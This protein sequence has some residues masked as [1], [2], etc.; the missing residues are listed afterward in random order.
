ME[1]LVNRSRPAI[2]QIWQRLGDRAVNG[3][4]ARLALQRGTGSSG[5]QGPGSIL[6]LLTANPGS[7]AEG[8]RGAE[9]QPGRARF[10]PSV[11]GNEH[12]NSPG[13][14]NRTGL[15][16]SVLVLSPQ[17]IQQTNG[18]PGLPALSEGTIPLPGLHCTRDA[19]SA[20]A[21]STYFSLCP[22]ADVRRSSCHGVYSAQTQVAPRNPASL[23]GIKSFLY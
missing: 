1:R 18:R 14:M 22:R 17:V 7:S 8:R 12:K 6:R 23:P 13:R 5:D 20:A 21:Q 9:I 16:S 3:V 11:G 2:V 19:C 4:H 15:R 10:L